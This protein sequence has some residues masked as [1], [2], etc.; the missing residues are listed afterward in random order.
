MMRKNMPFAEYQD[1][2][3]VNI[4][5]LKWMT[6]SPAHYK[7]QITLG[8]LAKPT[9]AQRLGQLVHEAVLQPQEFARHPVWFGGARRGKEWEAFRA[10]HASAKEPLA[11]ADFQQVCRIRDSV[12]ADSR[13]AELLDGPVD[14]SEVSFRWTD[15]STSIGC[16]GR[17]DVLGDNF[18][19]DLKTTT[20]ASPKA[21]AAQAWKLGYH[22]Q[23]AYYLDGARAEGLD[24][25]KFYF[26]AVETSA[27]YAVQV[28]EASP[29]FIDE[30]RKQY[31]ELLQKLVVCRE[32]KCWPAYGSEIEQ[33]MPPAWIEDC[34]E[35]TLEEMG[36]KSDE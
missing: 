3:G 24:A 5:S 19:V 25:S 33:L 6:R 28:Y 29:E 9:A 27:P 4:S 11:E 30:G 35:A 34:E 10:E 32:S 23:A 12:T 18:I 14:D 13:A 22:I 2:E 21:F 26:V 7:H 31:L 1:M 17:V 36:E 8:H 20:N 16:K 15:P